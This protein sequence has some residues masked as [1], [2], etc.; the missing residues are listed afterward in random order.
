MWVRSLQWKDP[1]DESTSTHS[2]VLAWRI[3]GQRSLVG[4]GPEGRKEPD[5]T[6]VTSHARTCH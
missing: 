2:S 4:Y 3:H 5:M 6:K 1:L